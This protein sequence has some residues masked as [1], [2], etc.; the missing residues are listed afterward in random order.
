[1]TRDQMRAHAEALVADW[2]PLTDKQRVQIA[3]ALRP[4][5]P[6]AVRR[7]RRPVAVDSPQPAPDRAA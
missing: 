7:R 1:M 6:P 3:A 2:P 5:A 4:D